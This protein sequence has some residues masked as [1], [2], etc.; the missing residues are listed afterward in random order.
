M[1][2]RNQAENYWSRIDCQR[3]DSR[4]SCRHQTHLH[5]QTLF[6]P[7]PKLPLST[8]IWQKTDTELWCHPQSEGPVGSCGETKAWPGSSMLTKEASLFPWSKEQIGRAWVCSW[9]E[10]C[11]GHN[12]SGGHRSGLS[13]GVTVALVGKKV[14]GPSAPRPPASEQPGPW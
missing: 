13:V 6:I 11:R 10:Q 9:T 14:T 8:K 7:N 1:G 5:T 12:S 4:V 2:W 3:D